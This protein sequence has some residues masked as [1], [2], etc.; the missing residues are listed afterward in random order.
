MAISGRQVPL[1]DT[2]REWVFD[3]TL[4]TTPTF[5]IYY[6]GIWEDEKGGEK[7]KD[8]YNLNKL[9]KQQEKSL[10][11]DDQ[12]LL[13]LGLIN[14]DLT[15]TDEGFKFQRR[16]LFEQNREVLAQEAAKDIAELEAKE[17]A[18]KATK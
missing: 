9:T 15:P 3:P 6:F 10:N 5:P 16:F 14:D 1:K 12:A 2:F 13:R 18:N 8:M 7:E 4:L 11:P 17:V